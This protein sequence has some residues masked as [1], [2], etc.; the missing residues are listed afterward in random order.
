MHINII[1]EVY[2]I[3]YIYYG[4][5]TVCNDVLRANAYLLVMFRFN[6]YLADMNT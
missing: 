6:D 1:L 4:I 5:R 2:F 3:Y